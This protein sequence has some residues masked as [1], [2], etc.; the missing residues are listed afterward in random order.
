ML[1]DPLIKQSL[2]IISLFT[3]FTLQLQFIL[4]NVI[5]RYLIDLPYILAVL[6]TKVF[7]N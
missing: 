5:G 3:T 6:S 1:I 7:L 4:P 2:Y